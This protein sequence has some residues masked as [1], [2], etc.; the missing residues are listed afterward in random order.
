VDGRA[1]QVEI[2]LTDGQSMTASLANGYWLAWWPGTTLAARVV[3][4]DAG[5]AVLADVAVGS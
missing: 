5:G 4:R 3:A 2:R 1:S